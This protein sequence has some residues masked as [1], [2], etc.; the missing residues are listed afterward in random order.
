VSEIGELEKDFGLRPGALGGRREG[1][2]RNNGV[3]RT[4]HRPSARRA[5]RPRCGRRGAAHRPEVRTS[6]AARTSRRPRRTGSAPPSWHA[7]HSRAPVLSSVSRCAAACCPWGGRGRR[8]L[9]SYL[10]GEYTAAAVAIVARGRA[11]VVAGTLWA[12]NVAKCRHLNFGTH[13]G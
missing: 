12:D 10:L 7:F 13:L 2:Q 9:A 5:D 8:D 4:R 1:D 11:V 3:R 6:R